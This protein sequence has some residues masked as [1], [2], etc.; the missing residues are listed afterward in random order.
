MG[1]LKGLVISV[2][3]VLSVFPKLFLLGKIYDITMVKTLGAP[4]IGM[5]QM[6]AL[7]WFAA[8]ITYRHAV[9]NIKDKKDDERGPLFNDICEILV[10]LLTWGLSSLVFG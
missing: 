6:L 3:S 1:F 4:H 10:L 7:S 9:R 2:F 8:A 5:W